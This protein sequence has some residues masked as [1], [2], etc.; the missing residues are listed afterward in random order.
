[1]ELPDG[2]IAQPV[3]RGVSSSRVQVAI[4]PLGMVEYDG[5]TLPI[6]S[7]DGR[8][9]AVQQGKAPAWPTILAQDDQTPAEAARL[10]VYEVTDKGL[11]LIALPTETPSGLLLGRDTSMRGFLVE[12]VRRDGSRWIGEIGWIRGGFRWLAQGDG[13]YSQAAFMNGGEG[14]VCSYR[15]KGDE[16][17]ALIAID[18]RGQR[19]LVSE[20]GIAWVM[21]T[22]VAGGEMIFAMCVREAGVEIGAIG[23][24][25]TGGNLLSRR[26]VSTDGDVAQAFQA[27]SSV[28]PS[29]WDT[30]LT[31]EE[32]GF[33]FVHPVQARV[34]LFE[35]RAGTFSPMGKGTVAS[36]RWRGDDGASGYFLTARQ[37]LMYL[38]DAGVEAGLEPARVLGSPFVA[39]AVRD[40][41]G[42][43]MI[44]F[45]PSKRGEGVMEVMRVAVGVP[46][47]IET[48]PESKR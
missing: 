48:K 4:V 41:R 6:V 43:S 10:A 38:P 9:I 16:S 40:Q 47:A 37:G 28:Q 46:K 11:Q 36:V 23:L 17:A 5:Q 21:G 33:A 1:M 31:S 44:A 2:T 29:C 32:G 35:P 30:K 8:F 18:S 3:T 25:A 13:I 15:E 7:P 22:P 34:V 19:V 45:G 39:R 12:S 20:S 42:P 24:G 27:M 14:I 26:R